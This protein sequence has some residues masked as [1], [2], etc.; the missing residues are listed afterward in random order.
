MV[1][2]RGESQ[3]SF[4]S[5][6]KRRSTPLAG[7]HL[8]RLCVASLHRGGPFIISRM[9]WPK[10]ER[11]GFSV[12]THHMSAHNTAGSVLCKFSWSRKSAGNKTLDE[13]SGPYLT[14]YSDMHETHTHTHSFNTS[15]FIPRYDW[16]RLHS[17][18][19]FFSLSFRVISKTFSLQSCSLSRAIL[20]P[21]CKN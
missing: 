11:L 16:A 15:R 10:I 13:N 18:K 9:P 20:Q 7:G 3:L 2:Q 6:Y 19:L 8:T 4:M 17:N 21:L 5:E 14:T 1:P 12:S